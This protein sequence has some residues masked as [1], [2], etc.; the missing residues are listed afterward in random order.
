MNRKMKYIALLLAVCLLVPA[1]AACGGGKEPVVV[2][3]DELVASVDKAIG[4]ADSMVAIDDSYIKGSMK[5][6]VS[7]YDGH[8]VKVNAYGVNIDEYG[9]FKAGD[10]EQVKEL[11]EAI[12]AYLKLRDDSWMTEYMP[13]EY[14]KLQAAEQKTQGLYVMYAILSDEG[15][16]AAF[17]AFDKMFAE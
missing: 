14:P 5:M 1:L 8:V 15:K 7:D 3:F 10:E 17:K 2:D 12:T 6:E 16:T 11:E 4:A 13:E 9:I